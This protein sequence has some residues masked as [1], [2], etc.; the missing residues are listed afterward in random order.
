M[1]EVKEATKNYFLITQHTCAKRIDLVRIDIELA[2]LDEIVLLGNE[3][4]GL[5]LKMTNAYMIFSQR[6]F[7][8]TD[9]LQPYLK[10]QPLTNVN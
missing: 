2:L 8:F 3:L 5:K 1:F 9:E 10:I 4:I 6:D 7:T